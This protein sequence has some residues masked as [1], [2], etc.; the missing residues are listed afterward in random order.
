MNFCKLKEPFPANDIEWRIQQSGAKNGK[1]WAMCLAYV[2]NRAIMER[3]DI[4]IGPDKWKNEYKTGP[5]GGI[6]CGISIKIGD[7]WVTKWDGAEN[8]KVEAVK[9]GLSGAMK[10]AAVQW[11][12][13]RYLYNLEAN[14]ANFVDKGQYKAKIDGKYYQWNPPSLPAWALPG[15]TSPTS[16]LITQKQIDTFGEIAKQINIDPKRL[17]TE[18]GFTTKISATKADEI[19]EEIKKIHNIKGAA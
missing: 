19:I 15:K 12:I 2:T 6:L 16:L 5:D 13:G 3:L 8:T 9:G 17:A 10:R 18:H 7:E 14:W 11:G 1:P 4:V